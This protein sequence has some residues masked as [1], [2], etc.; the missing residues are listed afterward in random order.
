VL[1]LCSS[2]LLAVISGNRGD[3]AVAGSPE[4]AHADR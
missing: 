4:R 1:F 3:E 2:G